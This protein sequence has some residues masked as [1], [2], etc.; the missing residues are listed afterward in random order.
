MT[1][2]SAL[3]AELTQNWQSGTSPTVSGPENFEEELREALLVQMKGLEA[4]L[5]RRWCLNTF[6]A[7]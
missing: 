7:G 5:L 6:D 3:I 2:I 1:R 4:I